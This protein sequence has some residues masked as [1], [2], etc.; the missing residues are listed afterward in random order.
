[1]RD[2]GFIIAN[3][4]PTTEGWYY[5][6]ESESNQILL[7]D[8]DSAFAVKYNSKPLNNATPGSTWN[9]VVSSN[10]KKDTLSTKLGAAASNVNIQVALASVADL[11]AAL[12]AGGEIFVDESVV[13]D[14]ENLLVFNNSEKEITVNLGDSALNTSGILR[15][16]ANGIIPVEVEQGTVN[17]NG[18][19]ISTAGENLNYHGQTVA[20]ALQTST[21]TT[22]NFDGT[23]F[24]LATTQSQ[25][26]IFGEA[27]LKNVTINATKSG[28]E[29][30][31]N[32][33]ITL[34]NV[35]ITADGGTEW[36]GACVWACNFDSKKESG[37]QDSN[38]LHNGS[39]LITIKSGN[40]TSTNVNQ[41][42]GSITAC[43]GDIVIE[44]G[45]F[46]APTG[47]MFDVSNGSEIKIT[48]GTF[49]T[50]AFEKNSDSFCAYLNTLIADGT[51]TKTA[52][53][54]IIK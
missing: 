3:I 43:G 26:R 47:K 13:L 42:Y 50:K 25:I 8:S 6:W 28:V 51:A 39:A 54:Y 2:A 15:G 20:Y 44:G 38:K 9:F 30:R 31:Y 16:E 12:A 29:T 41:G 7:V 11:S 46:T 40:Y 27:T 5:V 10:A 21:G 4:N 35:T 36:Y 19:V 1:M 18:G 49:N 32:G 45:T 17:F 22:S 52:D 23:T 48:G 24:D 14:K 34:E 33:Q 53:G 37:E